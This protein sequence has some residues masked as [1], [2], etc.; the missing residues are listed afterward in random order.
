MLGSWLFFMANIL[1]N[2]LFFIFSLLKLKKNSFMWDAKRVREEHCQVGGVWGS[3]GRQTSCI[4]SLPVMICDFRSVWGVSL[5]PDRESKRRWAEMFRQKWLR[6][7]QNQAPGTGVPSTLLRGSQILQDLRGLHTWVP[8]C[9]RPLIQDSS[10]KSL[11]A[12]QAPMLPGCLTQ[13]THSP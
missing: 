11:H 7:W 3:P 10:I 13:F 5:D 6:R 9:W 12:T 1:L 8:G 4:C 2:F